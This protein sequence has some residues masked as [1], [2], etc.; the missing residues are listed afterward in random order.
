MKRL[1]EEEAANIKVVPRGRGTYLRHLLL[2]MKPGEIIL[3]EPNE[4]NW[5]KKPLSTYIRRLEKANKRKFT[6]GK[7]MDGSGWVVRRVR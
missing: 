4:F 5:K 6:C 1:T 2:S 7:A 3:V